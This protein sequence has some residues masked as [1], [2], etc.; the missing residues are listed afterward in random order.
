MSE[1]TGSGFTV[2]VPAGWEVDIRPESAMLLGSDHD[3]V[4][5]AVMHLANFQLPKALAEYGDELYTELGPADVFVSVIDFGPLEPGQQL[6]SHLGIPSSLA[7]EDF[8]PDAAVRGLAGGTATQYFFQ[9]AGRGYCLF[10]VVGSHRERSDILD[11]LN[12]VLS[13]VRF[14][15]Q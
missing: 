4:E 7:P 15:T 5:P 6:F 3:V 12:A 1:V 2:D 14:D 13:T 10:I 8:S 9:E 11:E